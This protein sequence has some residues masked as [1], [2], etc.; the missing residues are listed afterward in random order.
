MSNIKELDYKFIEDKAARLWTQKD[1]AYAVGMTPEGLSLKKNRYHE[2]VAALER[3]WAKAR[4][5]IVISN[6]KLGLLMVMYQCWYIL[7]NIIAGRKIL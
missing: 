4:G 1:I 7:E 6:M 2:L 5:E 3:G